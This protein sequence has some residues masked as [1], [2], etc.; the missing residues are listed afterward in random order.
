MTYDY[1]R[2]YYNYRYITIQKLGDLVNNRDWYLLY[3]R[4]TIIIIN[5]VFIYNINIDITYKVCGHCTSV[6]FFFSLENI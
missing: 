1:N 2:K 6:S 3:D 4:E 5:T